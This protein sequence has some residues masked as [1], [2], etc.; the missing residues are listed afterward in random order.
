MCRANVG[1]SKDV[2]NSDIN[3]TGMS[4]HSGGFD[5]EAV[6]LVFPLRPPI[7]Q[8]AHHATNSDLPSLSY[9]RYVISGGRRRMPARR[10]SCVKSVPIFHAKAAVNE[11]N[12]ILFATR[13]DGLCPSFLGNRHFLWSRFV[14]AC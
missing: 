9:A 3:L 10:E 7:V 14:R 2:H 1:G 13:K 4:P 5:G 12:A 8:S 6:N 11:K